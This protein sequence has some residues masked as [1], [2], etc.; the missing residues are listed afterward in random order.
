VKTVEICFFVGFNFFLNMSIKTSKVQIAEYWMDNCPYDEDNM[1]VDIIDMR[2]HC[3]NCGNEKRFN[4]GNDANKTRLQR[5]HIIPKALGGEDTP[6]N[7]VLLCS[8][9]H[10]EAPN[11]LSK[12]AM[13]KWIRSNYTPLSVYGT[14]EF[15][16]ALIEFKRKHGK[17]FLFDVL[18]TISGDIQAIYKEE[19]DKVST[20]SFNRINTSTLLFVLE[21]IW[22]KNIQKDL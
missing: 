16:K 14:Y 10:Q 3:W 12:D 15:R 6:S 4:G 17:S 8:E 22:E 19:R 5:C 2:F 18:P 13:W 20:H 9:C 21:S 11:C 7:F 1:N